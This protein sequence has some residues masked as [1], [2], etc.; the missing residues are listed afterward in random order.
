MKKILSLV[1]V[2]AMVLS[3]FAACGNNAAPETTGA[4]ETTAPAEVNY[5]NATVI[6]YTGNVR[7]NAEVYSQI[8]AAKAAYEEKGATVILVDAG[9]YLQGTAY[10]NSDMGLTVYNL[11]DAAGYNVAG[12]GVYEFVYGEATTGYM[13]HGNVTKYFTQAELVAGS[14]ELEYQKNAPWAETAVMDVRAAKAP[15]SFK[16]ICSNLNITSEATGYYA[17]ENSVVLGDALKVGFVSYVPENVA[18]YLQDEFL[19]GYMLQDVTAPE[20]D[21]LVALNGTGDI[22]IEAAADGALTVGAYVIDN[23]TKAITEETVELTGSDAAVEAVIAAAQLSNVIGK[24]E[25]ILDGSDRNN[26][27]GQTNLGALTADALAWYAANKIEGI[28]YPIVAIQNGG[29]CDNFIYTG[30]IT[31]V[32]MLNALPFSPMGVGVVAMTGEKLL[33]TIEASTQSGMCPGWAQVSGIEYTV[34]TTAAYDA[35]E[36]YGDFFMANSVNRVAITSEGFDPAATYAVVCDRFLINGNDTYYT[37]ADCE[38]IGG[39]AEGVKTRDVVAMYIDEVLGG[40]IGSDY[41]GELDNIQVESQV[42]KAVIYIS[43]LGGVLNAFGKSDCIVGAYGSLAESYGVPSCGSWNSV[44]VE[45]VI[46]T[47][48]DAIFGYAKY[49]TDEQI[50]QLR[51]AGIFCYFIELSNADTA[52]DEIMALGELFGCEAK[53]QEFVDL[54]NKYDAL[55]KDRLTTV[56]PL[57]VYVEGT[58]K[59]PFKTA[60]GTSAAHKLVTGAGLNNLYGDHE[61]TYPERNLEDVITKNPDIVVKLCGGSDTLGDELYD[62]YVADLAG[63]AAVD[64]GKVIMLNNECGTTAIGSVIGRLYI[65]KYAYPELFEDVD[66]DAV[67]EELRAAGF[68]DTTKYTGSGAFFK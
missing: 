7:G 16:V 10:A 2:L 24:S 21:V 57:N 56:E 9:N 36:A 55:L 46:A 3:M 47:G 25:V 43:S 51:D 20:C 65:A 31:E 1:L 23:T 44:D 37:M 62:A 22:S 64:A 53:A 15:A 8:A 5:A 41:A 40:T 29:N 19:K 60:N 6:L 58:N 27:N 14:E 34:D 59:D 45:A 13:Y 26:W 63:V 49:T 4:P 48:A 28:E 30:E 42:E 32:D 54:Y 33:E 68:C 52:A 12:M 38:V 17:F 50:A 18:T 35:G 61:T 67:Y 39:A 66:V 11:M